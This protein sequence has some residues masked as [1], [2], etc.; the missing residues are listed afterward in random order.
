[1]VDGGHFLVT[2]PISWFA[3]ATVWVESRPGV[4]GLSDRPK[5][6]EAARMVL[7]RLGGACGLRVRLRSPL[8]LGKGMASSTADIAATAAAAARALGKELSPG[9]VASLA[10]GIEPTD[11]VFFPGIVLFDHLT[12]R[13]L[14]FLGP[15][16]ALKVLIVDPGGEVETISFNRRPE[17]YRLNLAKEAEVRKALRLVR[18]GM[19]EGDVVKVAKGATLSALANQLILPKPEL[20]PLI[21]VTASCGALGVN[22]AHSGTVMGVLYRDGEADLEEL[23]SRV[24]ERFPYVRLSYA[25]LVDG[26]IYPLSPRTANSDGGASS[27]RKRA[28]RK[29]TRSSLVLGGSR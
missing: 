21:K 17:L 13:R 9:E 26:G 6:L 25:E 7:E 10:L 28:L 4:F 15:A 29:A 23:E 12:G 27:E 20:E 14:E 11:G 16:P 19:A 2:C 22:V 5:A 24:R 8:P 1:V 3:E 18:E